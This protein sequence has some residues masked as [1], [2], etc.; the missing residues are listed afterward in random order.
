MQQADKLILYLLS[1][2][3]R[4][5]SLLSLPSP[6]FYDCGV[7]IG[8]PATDHLQPL[9]QQKLHLHQAIGLWTQ[10]HIQAAA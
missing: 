1:F 7:A 2:F 4:A 6:V 10:P 8:C 3:A 5:I 9:V